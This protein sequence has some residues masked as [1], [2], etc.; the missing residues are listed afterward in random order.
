MCYRGFARGCSRLIPP[1][2]E[3]AA[4]GRRLAPQK[5]ARGGLRLELDIDSERCVKKL[6]VRDAARACRHASTTRRWQRLSRRTVVPSL[7][8]GSPA[9]V[10]AR[11]DGY[12][13]SS[14]LLHCRT[15]TLPVR[16]T[17]PQ[18]LEFE[19]LSHYVRRIRVHCSEGCIRGDTAVLQCSHLCRE[20]FILHHYGKHDLACAVD[21]ECNATV[22]S[23]AVDIATPYT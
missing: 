19:R 10:R 13:H 17:A 21:G 1:M 12:G 9:H 20:R 11:N 2:P 16:A 5:H 6:D 3:T 7:P 8:L 22:E 15:G 14:L 23:F 4:G 18:A